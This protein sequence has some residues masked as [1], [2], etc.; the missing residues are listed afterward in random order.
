MPLTLPKPFSIL[1]KVPGVAVIGIMILQYA[2]MSAS[3]DS[4][5]HCEL[6]IQNPHQSTHAAEYLGLDV[7]K[8]KV[9]SSCNKP[10]RYTELNA[11]IREFEG[12]KSKKIAE[13]LNQIALVQKPSDHDVD[14]ERLNIPCKKGVV[15][16]Y[17]GTAEGF[18]YLK[19]GEK[20]PVTG[21]SGK[22]FPVPCKIRAN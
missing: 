1:P 13:F 6:R 4:A 20:I 7:V 12:K 22:P 17:F 9:T 3:S 16:S 21:S 5:P 19:T 11:T 14:F 8:L 18:A 15:V 2:W 10:Q